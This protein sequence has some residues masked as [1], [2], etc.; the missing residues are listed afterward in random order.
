MT[1]QKLSKLK[2]YLDT[3]VIS[4]LEQKDAPEKMAETIQLWK[5]FEK[6]EYEVYISDIVINEINKC[7]EEKR[8][9]LLKHLRSIDYNI[10]ET[11]HNVIELAKKIVQFGVLKAKSIE[12][13]QHIAAAIV[14][15]C[16]AITSWNFKHIA[17]V[18]TI[19]GIRAIT[20]L[21][22]YKELLIYP[23][24]VFLEE[25]DEDE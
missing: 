17:N 5:M 6:G 24:S 7:N 9:L 22:G 21:E 23:P 15:G 25:V 14:S 3:S 13:C 11:N 16:D 2:V 4:Y 8:K 1:L 20:A 10:I 19:R 12:D 18:K